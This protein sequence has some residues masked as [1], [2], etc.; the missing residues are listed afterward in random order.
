M[1]KNVFISITKILTTSIL[2]LLILTSCQHPN[3]KA[4]NQPV[5]NKS[6]TKKIPTT[7]SSKLIVH[8]DS[9]PQI[10][11]P[12]GEGGPDQKTSPV[13]NLSEF[14]DKKLFGLPLTRIKTQIG[15]GI[16]DDDRVDS[17]FSLTDNKFKASWDL[18]AKT[19]KFFVIEINGVILA[20][21][22]YDLKVIDA[23]NT[24]THDPA[25]NN[26]FNADRYSTINRDLTIVL[27]HKW[28]MVGE[29]GNDEN[30]KDDEDWFINKDGR[31]I[32]K[33]N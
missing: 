22:T 2:G 25:N 12:Y 31:F 6:D 17:T 33:I 27:H 4:F 16:L 11:F 23:I 18:I 3:S 10:N 15:G 1:K 28:Y 26:H 8:L 9:L 5:E 24:E 7:D 30:E 29:S 32:R 21:L 13:L 19:P 20:T 14:K